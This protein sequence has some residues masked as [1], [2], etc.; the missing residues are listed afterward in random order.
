MQEKREKQKL[1]NKKIAE[2][3]V[4]RIREKSRSTRSIGPKGKVCRNLST[5]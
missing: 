2:E 5:L 3:E 4:E 1:L